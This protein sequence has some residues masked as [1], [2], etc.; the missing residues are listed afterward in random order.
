MKLTSHVCERSRADATLHATLLYT[1]TYEDWSGMKLAATSAD[2]FYWCRTI[3]LSARTRRRFD[4]QVI[5]SELPR[6]SVR[7]DP[8]QQFLRAL[9]LAARECC[10]IVHDRAM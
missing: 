9:W 7:R 10:P 1:I 4:H 8:L 2:K 5:N 3:L 6:E